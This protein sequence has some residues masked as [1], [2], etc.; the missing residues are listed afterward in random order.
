MRCG[1]KL[2]HASLRKEKV[3]LYSMWLPF[4]GLASGVIQGLL[5]RFEQSCHLRESRRSF[6]RPMTGSKQLDLGFLG[7]CLNDLFS[8]CDTPLTPCDMHRL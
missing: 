5:S 8:P 6:E 2:P 3:C 7:V 4:R 1:L